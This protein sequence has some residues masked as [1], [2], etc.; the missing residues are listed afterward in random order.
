LA[1][2]GWQIDTGRSEMTDQPSVTLSLRAL[3]PSQTSV[4]DLAKILFVRCRE[5]ELDVL[6]ATGSVL[7]AENDMTPVRLRWGTAAPE[8]AWWSRSADLTAAFAP[9]PR[10]FVRRLV[11]T[12]SLRI[13]IHRADASR[14]VLSFD[15]RGLD[16]YMQRL[17]AA[18]PP[19]GDKESP[20][21]AVIDFSPSADQVFI[22]SVVEEAPEILSG[23]ALTYPDNPGFDA[24]AREY[25][26]R[27]LFRPGRVHGRPVR[28]LLNL[29]I[30]YKISKKP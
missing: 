5:A 25:V 18:C 26:L 14:A 15:A 17:D 2:R 13:E 19:K 8:E 12:P 22:E 11:A 30:D 9:E 20:D 24:P 7:D 10:E 4:L 27:A 1:N 28:V 29:P 16:R 6:V 3:S 21:T 23:P